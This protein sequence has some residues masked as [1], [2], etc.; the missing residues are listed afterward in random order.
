MLST[1]LYI[2]ESDKML[3][4]PFIVLSNRHCLIISRLVVSAFNS[5]KWWSKQKSFVLYFFQAIVCGIN[6]KQTKFKK[7]NTIQEIRFGHQRIYLWQKHKLVV[8]GSA[9]L[10]GPVILELLTID[11]HAKKPSYCKK[12]KSWDEQ[13]LKDS[14]KK[15]SVILI[16]W[17]QHWTLRWSVSSLQY[18]F[19][20]L[21]L[22]H[23]SWWCLFF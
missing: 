21:V 14:V 16:L 18:C 6:C 10:K 13:F 12:N 3:S 15:L 11:H 2:G 23:K 1:R 7:G 9:S 8:T 22:D 20:S 4:H 5:S 17:R 19:C